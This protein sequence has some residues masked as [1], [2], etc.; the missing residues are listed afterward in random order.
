MTQKKLV[1]DVINELPD[2]TSLA[3]IV[4]RIEFLPAVQKGIGP[5]DRGGISPADFILHPS[6]FILSFRPRPPI[7]SF[8]LPPSEQLLLIPEFARL[9]P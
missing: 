8:I 1:L 9:A 5:F 6:A 3:E 7:S 4:G 2:E